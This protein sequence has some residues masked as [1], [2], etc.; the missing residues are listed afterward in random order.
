M[1]LSV[2]LAMQPPLQIYSRLY[3]GA[4]RLFPGLF[5][6]YFWEQGLDEVRESF[7]ILKLFEGF[8]V[9]FWESFLGL[10]PYLQIFPISCVCL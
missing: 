5:S 8:N 6:S 2:H 3:Q 1:S 9:Q 4:H 7:R 10:L